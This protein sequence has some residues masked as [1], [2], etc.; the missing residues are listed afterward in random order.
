M[1]TRIIPVDDFDLVI[2]GATGDLSQR[3][4]LPALFHRDEQ[5]QLPDGAC[6]I[7]TSRKAMTNAEF[8]DFAAKAIDSHAKFMQST[9]EVYRALSQ[10]PV[11]PRCRSH[12]GRRLGGSGTGTR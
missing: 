11:L 4:L 9:P 8:R 2:F 1:T 12:E 3:K 10:S 7:G 6:I 5:G